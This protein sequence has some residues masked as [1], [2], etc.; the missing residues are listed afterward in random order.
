MDIAD[1]LKVLGVL[2]EIVVKI[3]ADGAFTG[4]RGL[5]GGMLKAAL[6]RALEVEL[7]ERVGYGCG[8]VEVSLHENS[9]NGTS[10][11]T[12]ATEIGDVELVILRD[13][14]GTFTPMLVP[15]GQRRLDGR[16]GMIISPPRSAPRS[17]TRRSR[18]SSTKSAR[19]S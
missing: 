19:R 14:N 15:K 7:T 3:D 13:R 5:I 10:P 17:A 4:G 11:K 2:D 1:Q 8:D 9:R 6:E 12:V 16:D 18:R